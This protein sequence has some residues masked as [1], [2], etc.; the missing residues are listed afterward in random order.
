MDHPDEKLLY[1]FHKIM[2]HS[3]KYI[4]CAHKTIFVERAKLFGWTNQMVQQSNSV[5]SIKS[6]VASAA[7]SKFCWYNQTFVGTI[8]LLLGQPN[9]CLFN[10]TF[11]PV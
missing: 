7:T 9:F 4:Y 10:Q 6:S 11:F 1:C 2:V 5:G 3:T 8:K